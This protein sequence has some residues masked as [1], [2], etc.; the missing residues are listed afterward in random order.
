MNPDMQ[1]RHQVF[2]ALN[3]DPAACHADVGVHVQDGV[4]TLTGQLAD[5]TLK[6]AVERA[7][8]RV[9]GAKALVNQLTVRFTPQEPEATRTDP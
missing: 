3:W 4:V 5:Q 2:E 7:V 8:Q 6:H 1:L 9:T